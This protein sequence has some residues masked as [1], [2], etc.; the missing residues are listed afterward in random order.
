MSNDQWPGGYNGSQPGGEGDDF[1]DLDN[2]GGDYVPQAAFRP[3]LETLANGEYDFEFA[4][5]KLD[6]IKGDTVLRASLKVNGGR[7]VEYL[8]WLNKNEAVNR[9]G[10]DMVTLGFDADRWGPA[11]G[12]P[13]SRE[14]PA[15]AAKLR[16]VKFRGVKASRPRTDFLT[17]QPTG[18]HWH[19]LHIGCRIDGR[20]MPP[21]NSPTRQTAAPAA[22]MNRLPAGPD[23][24]D[25]KIPF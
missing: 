14:I 22:G 21:L 5:A 10:A 13:L 24:D 6:K 25:E 7:T 11:H 12:R 16:G 19:D 15:V 23:P 1:G 2:Y 8:W 4:E 9:F 20:P 18:E 3:G 17:K